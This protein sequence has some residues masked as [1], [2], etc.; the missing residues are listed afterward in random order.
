MD[1]LGEI[2]P[3]NSRFVKELLVVCLRDSNDAPAPITGDENHVCKRD[4]TEKTP[5]IVAAMSET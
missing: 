3:R 1:S 4:I 5:K 2:V